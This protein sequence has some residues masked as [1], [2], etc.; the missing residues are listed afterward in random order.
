MRL[1]LDVL[2]SV[3]HI[4]TTSESVR[5]CG[6]V[7]EGRERDTG[8]KGTRGMTAVGAGMTALAARISP[9]PALRQVWSR[10]GHRTRS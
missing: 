10:H 4:I 2:T 5:E 3:D 7:R 6:S 8:E 9:S 1:N